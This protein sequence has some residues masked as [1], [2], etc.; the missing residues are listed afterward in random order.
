MPE[1]F[2]SFSNSI[3]DIVGDTATLMSLDGSS[4]EHPLRR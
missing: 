3:G 1:Y 2:S 4:L